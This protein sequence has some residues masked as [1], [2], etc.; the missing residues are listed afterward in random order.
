MHALQVWQENNPVQAAKGLVRIRVGADAS[1]LIRSYSNQSR[2]GYAQAV[3][4]GAETRK[5]VCFTWRI[6]TCSTCT[7]TPGAPHQCSRNY[8][9]T[10]N[11]SEA[12]MVVAMVQQLVDDD[13]AVVAQ[14][15]IDGDATLQSKIIRVFG[16]DV[17]FRVFGE[18][19]AVA[20]K[21]DDRHRNTSIK[22]QLYKISEACSVGSQKPMEPGHDAYYLAAVPNLI[23]YKVR[24]VTLV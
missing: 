18:E 4:I 16:N 5:V 2:S 6:M 7:R 9:G 17:R 12:S 11:G 15:A 14:L 3:L 21:S 19:C 10:I 20:I 1:W 24:M 23:K 22:N 13:G 8:D